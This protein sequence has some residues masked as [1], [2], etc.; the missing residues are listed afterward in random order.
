MALKVIFP[1]LPL[2]VTFTEIFYILNWIYYFW[3]TIKYKPILRYKRRT[4]MGPY[5]TNVELIWAIDYPD[6]MANEI[7]EGDWLWN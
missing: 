3:G 2:K 7:Q 1:T 6:R 4:N 5:G